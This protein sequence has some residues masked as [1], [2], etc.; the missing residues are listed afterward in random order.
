MDSARFEDILNYLGADTVIVK[1][2]IEVHECKVK[3]FLR[4]LGIFDKEFFLDSDPK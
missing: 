1:I 2:D 3:G 4:L